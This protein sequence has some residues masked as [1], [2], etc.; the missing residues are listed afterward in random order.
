MKRN[1]AP[2]WHAE[3]DYVV[4]GA[5]TAGCVVAARLSESGKH[6]VLLLEAGERQTHYWLKVPLGIGKIRGD[7]RFHWKF[8]T[9]PERYMSGQRVYWPRGKVL[10]GS[11][12]VNGMIYN[13]GQPTD[14]DAWR[15]AGNQGWGF[16]DVLP[17]FKKVE[18]FAGGDP[19]WR[20]SDGPVYVTDLSS[21]PDPLSDAFVA[22]SVR[23]GYARIKD[24]NAGA[25]DVGTG[26]L[27][28]NIHKGLRCSTYVAYLRQAMSRQNLRIMRGAMARRVRFVGTQA[29][30]VEFTQFG[31]TGL[32]SAT[33]AVVLCA[34]TV[35]SPQILELSGIGHAQH[36][37]DL[38]I[39]VVQHSPGVGEN[40]QDHLQVRLVYECRLPIT[41]NAVLGHPTRLMAMGLR[42]A[43]QRKGLMTTAS[44]K[45]FTNAKVLPES[46]RADVKIQQYMISG[47]SRHPGG[48][49]LIV[50]RFW[51]FSIGHNQMRPESRGSIHI[52][53]TNPEVPPVIRANYLAHET[54]KRANVGALRVSRTIAS[55]PELARLIVSERRPGGNVQSDE[56]LLAYCGETGHTS[57]HPIGT[58]RM[59][60][61]AQAVVDPRLRVHGVHGLYVVDASIMPTLTSCNTNAPA[62]MIGERGA[63]F[64]L[65]D[66]KGE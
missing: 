34:G 19:E 42:F 26:Y 60:V 8:F 20:G 36:L 54:D 45:T 62:M 2:G 55:Q 61:D 29:K 15:D 50:D 43:L 63:A 53:S 46:K 13:R 16:S 64:I 25:N 56:E 14:Y 44:A 31:R 11:G 39:S 66:T 30:G 18:R 17:Y 65:E 12:S 5:G 48:A 52:D 47:D 4:I 28:L 33:R 6:R 41:L 58:C 38:G 10:G 27:Q 35:Q 49:D 24:Y 21:D 40:L 22:A 23:A 32:A 59:G 7:E 3:C 37:Q 51:G 9:E 57:Y 1:E